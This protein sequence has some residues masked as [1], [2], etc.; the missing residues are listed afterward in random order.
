M[1]SLEEALERLLAAIHP[2]PC[3]EAP[4]DDCH[5]RFLG[6]EIRSPID[7][8]PFDNSAMDGYAVRAADLQAAS[9]EKPATLRLAG[10]VPA[11][12]RLERPVAPGHCARIF[13]G[14]PLPEGCDAVVMQE[15]VAADG[16]AIQFREPARPFENVRLKG[17]DI[18]AGTFLAGPGDRIDPA[19]LGLLAACGLAKIPVHRQPVVTLLA[20][21]SE[22]REPGAPLAEGEIYESNRAMLRPLAERLGCR[23]IVRPLVADRLET[24][25]A[26]LAKGF[27]ESDAVITTGGV[28]VGEFDFVKQAFAALGGSL[29]LWKVSVRPGKP[30]AFGTLSAQYF[31]GLPGNPVSA[32]VTFLLLVR[33][34]LLRLQNARSLALPTLGG[35][36]AEPLQNQGERRHFLRVRWH[37]GQVS[38][39]GPQASH[40]LSS[41]AGSNGLVDVPPRTRWEAGT[42]VKVQLWS[43]AEF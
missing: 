14:S 9:A 40:M 20:T 30:F 31:F 41:L 26:A 33:P 7:L 12:G 38:L 23:V 19:R 25:R 17:E 1:I 3:Q 6:A 35:R 42:E 32:L 37:E 24:T 21:G 8:P 28:S 10:I 16:P 29:G 13:T 36:L 5:G 11:G 22:L 39:C 2:L 15:D 43:A 18:R 27:A 34:A 4:L